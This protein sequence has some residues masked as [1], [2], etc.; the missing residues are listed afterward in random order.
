MA[1][2][3]T[4]VAKDAVSADVMR[5]PHAHAD[6]LNLAT[7]IVSETVV[8]VPKTVVNM[9]KQAAPMRVSISIPKAKFQAALDVYWDSVKDKLPDNV[10]QQALKGYREVTRERVVKIAGGELQFYRP[11]VSKTIYDEIKDNA[12]VE[13]LHV[14]QADM[15]EFPNVY[16]IEAIVFMTPEV[17]LS[18]MNVNK[19]FKFHVAA[20]VISVNDVKNIVDAKVKDVQDRLSPKSDNT[21][22]N[23]R[24]LDPLDDALALKAG[25]KTFAELL[26]SYEK[27]AEGQLTKNL[28]NKVSE[29]MMKEILGFAAVTPIPEPWS[30]N[31]GEELFNRQAGQFGGEESFLKATHTTKLQIVTQFAQNVANQLKMSLALR[32]LGV[33][34]G[35]EGDTSLNSSHIYADTVHKHLL[36]TMVVDVGDEVKVLGLIYTEVA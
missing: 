26:Q 18:N 15:K 10:V 25:F 1:A 20:P 4:T 30:Y 33:K 19:D 3:D 34:M 16:N 28:E 2:N 21:L 13:A 9:V 7:P 27:E 29:L 22:A 8:P 23:P 36:K 11:V 5:G 6:T 14:A 32:A 24:V 35:I 12:G 17:T 31:K